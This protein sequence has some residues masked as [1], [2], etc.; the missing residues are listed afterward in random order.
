MGDR[1][2]D[3]GFRRILN[4]LRGG[5]SGSLKHRGTSVSCHREEGLFHAPGR[6]YAPPVKG[7]MA[8]HD[9]PNIRAI[10]FVRIR[11]GGHVA[12]NVSGVMV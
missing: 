10:T 7:R 6:Q 1:P 3:I 5:S 2:G 12:R 4:V 9:W 8:S 11:R